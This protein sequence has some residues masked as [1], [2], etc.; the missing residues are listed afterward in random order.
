MPVGSFRSRLAAFQVSFD[1]LLDAY[2]EDYCREFDQML[3]TRADLAEFVRQYAAR[4]GK[5]L[6]P[7]L[8]WCGYRAA[9]GTDLGQAVPVAAAAEILHVFAL[10]HDDVMDRSDTRRGLPSAHRQAELWHAEQGL[11][12]DAGQFGISAAILLGDLALAISDGFIDLTR[13]DPQAARQLRDIWN[14][15]RQEVILGQFLDVVASY[16]PE[17]AP[18]DQIWTILS[19]KSGKYTLERPLHLGAASAGGN[20]Q[21]LEAL[22][23]YAIPLGRAFQLTDDI[24]GVFGDE[25][26]VGK[27]VDSDIR[28]GKS[29]LL[30]RKAYDAASSQQRER[31]LEGWGNTEASPEQIEGAR[32]VILDTGAREWTQSQADALAAEAL[33]ALESVDAPDDVKADLEGLA[34]YVLSRSS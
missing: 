33:Q 21:L 3:S 20:C 8:V 6:R 9:G 5:R 18:E 34:G 24:L 10:A 12:G 25:R 11:K 1:N 26:A 27:P 22:S 19:L 16:R 30:V 4:P 31:L 15:A 14:L 2:L 32:L 7:F 13:L 28:E 23:A 29:T 17:P